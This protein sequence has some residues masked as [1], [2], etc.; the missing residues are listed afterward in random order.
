MCW[1]VLELEQEG[2]PTRRQ[3]YCF[4]SFCLPEVGVAPSVLG[5]PRFGFWRCSFCADLQQ[6]S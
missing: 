1:G 2:D 3:L 4:V 5:A 6:E